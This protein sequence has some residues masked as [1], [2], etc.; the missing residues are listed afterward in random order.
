MELI[1]ATQKTA[2]E[3]NVGDYLVNVS[4]SNN[5]STTEYNSLYRITN[6]SQNGTDYIISY[7]QF[8]AKPIAQGADTGLRV[9]S[10]TLDYPVNGLAPYDEV[11]RTGAFNYYDDM[12][13]TLIQGNS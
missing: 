2:A 7:E 5:T 6:I 8:I 1:N 3:L 10:E 9:A 11:F 12:W 13:F 4:T